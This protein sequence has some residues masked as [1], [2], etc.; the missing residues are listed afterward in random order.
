MRGVIVKSAS[1][2]VLW[3]ERGSGPPRPAPARRTRAC[4]C[5]IRTHLRQ[6]EDQQGLLEENLRVAMV[7]VVVLVQE[8]VEGGAREAWVPYIGHS[9]A[10]HDDFRSAQ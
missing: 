2:A 9:A 1:A 10:G 4:Q 5:V 8:A 7:G 6:V 3:F